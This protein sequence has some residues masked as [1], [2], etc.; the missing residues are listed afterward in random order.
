MTVIEEMLNPFPRKNISLLPTPFHRLDRL[1]EETGCDL[2]IKRDD[3]TGFGFSGNKTRKLDFLIADALKKGCDSLIG[4]GANQ[5]NFCRILSAAGSRFNL[6]VFLVLNGEKPEKPTG[7][8]LMDHLLDAT[9]FHV[10]REERE[11]K[12]RKIYE[13]LTAE[14]RHVYFMPPGGSTVVGTL[15]YTAGFGEILDDIKKSAVNIHHIIHAS[16]SAGTQAG[17]VLGQAI[18]GWNGRITG[19]SVDVPEQELAHNVHHLASEAGKH[20]GIQINPNLIHTD[21]NYIGEGYGI[22][23]QACKDAIK[24]F[25]KK[26]G[27]FLDTV[28]TGKGASGF[29]DYCNK[30]LIRKN[31]PALFIHTGGNIQ[32]FE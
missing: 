19:I 14:G 22:P 18:S 11:L 27:I 30:G 13:R 21:G 23:T 31:E 9:I 4:I 16:S 10:S 8:L 17:L 7:N 25:A 32:L 20:L 26:E 29:L 5:S 3:L 24:G 2:W 15:G 6:D 12:A 1:S 28:Y